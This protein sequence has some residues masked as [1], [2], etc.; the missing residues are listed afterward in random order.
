MKDILSYSN[1]FFVYDQRN[2]KLP[3][4]FAEYFIIASNRYSYNTTWTKLK[5]FIHETFK[6]LH[7]INS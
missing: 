6:Q 7:I 4:N 1:F 2:E 5:A 3:D